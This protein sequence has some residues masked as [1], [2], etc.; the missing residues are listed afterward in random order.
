[1]VGNL[2]KVWLPV[3]IMFLLALMV[4]TSNSVDVFAIRCYNDSDCG[5]PT[6]N[7]YCNSLGQ[8]C[9][10]FTNYT[11]QNPGTE[12]SVCMGSASGGCANCTYGCNDGVCIQSNQSCRNESYGCYIG[13]MQCCAGLK[14]VPLAELASDGSCVA[15]N[16]GFVCRPCGNGVCD[17]NE[18]KCSCPEDCGGSTQNQTCIDSDGGRNYY[19]RGSLD[20]NCSPKALCGVW[21]DYCVDN[22]TLLEYSCDNLNGEFYACPAG[23]SDGACIQGGVLW[24]QVKCVFDGSSQVQ[25]CYTAGQNSRAYC[26][27]TETCIADISGYVSEQITWK[28]T[29][30]GYAYTIMDGDNE[31]ARFSCSNVKSCQ[32]NKCDDGSIYECKLENGICIC[33]AC[34]PIIVKPVCG[35]GICESGEGEVCT[36]AAA[37]ASC[38]EGKEC[39]IPPSVC[40]VACPQDCKPT[41]GI[42]AGIGKKF[43]LQVYQPAKIVENGEHVMKITFKDLIAYRCKETAVSSEAAETIESKVATNIAAITGNVIATAGTATPS[44]GAVSAPSATAGGSGGGG[45]VSPSGGTVSPAAVYSKTCTYVW[46]STPFVNQTVII[47]AYT[48]DGPDS[49]DSDSITVNV[50][51]SI[52]DR[53]P[54]GSGRGSKAMDGRTLAIQI[55]EPHTNLLVAGENKINV[56]AEGPNEMESIIL[57]IQTGNEGAGTQVIKIPEEDCVSSAAGGGG[58][59]ATVPI[60]RCISAGPKALLDVDMIVNSQLGKQ[61]TLNLDV[62][63]KKQVDEFTI[64]FLGYDYASMTGTF[65]VSREAFYCPKNCK[66]NEIGDVV[67]C[68]NKTCNNGQTLCPD[69]ICRDKCDIVTEDCKY[70]CLVD[71]KCFPMGVR[72]NGT[73]CSSNLVMSTQAGQSE[74]CENNFECESNVCAAGKCVSASL[75]DMIIKWFMGLF[76]MA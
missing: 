73:Y 56:Q 76:G 65:L 61:W 36:I 53:T 52:E 47:S 13:D 25:K 6:Y 14:A 42:Y 46:D 69:G 21:I 35:N 23:C 57:T 3:C 50:L 41:E 20:M 1:M 12:D 22:K 74:V 44:V 59:G 37:S 30:G 45:V 58:A 40:Y 60:L 18:N 68:A 29:C 38:Q 27:G 19:V 33:P 24:E 51:D 67:E 5:T 9:V 15:S 11:C 17:A 62:G 43:K 28:S 34:P 71:G 2:G 64:S 49:T 32:P 4:A 63:E 55:S 8:A 70:G 26:S 48:R 7:T 16:C 72:Y 54:T 39:A 10:N 66:C 31:Y 75:I